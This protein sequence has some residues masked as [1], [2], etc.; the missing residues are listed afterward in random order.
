MDGKAARARVVIQAVTPEID[1]GRFPIKRII[2]D[3]VTVEADVFCDGHEDGDGA[4]G[5]ADGEM[6]EHRG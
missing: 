3:K 4:V 2:G 6:A 1:C 5:Q